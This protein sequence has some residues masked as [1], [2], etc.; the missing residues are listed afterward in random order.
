MKDMY[1]II[2]IGKLKA[3]GN[4]AGV[5]SHMMRTRET[6]NSDGREN[7]VL[8]Q[9]PSLS[10][11]MQEISLYMPRKNAVLAYD[12]LLTASPEFFQDKTPEQV[13]EWAQDAFAWACRK[14]GRENI[15]GAV[16]HL[17][18][19]T[20]PHLQILALPITPDGER[21]CARHYTGGRE[22]MRALWTEYAAAMK[23]WGLVRGREYSPAKHVDVR[24]YYQAVNRA[25]ELAKVR[26][27]RP[28]ELPAP[29]LL[30]RV[31]PRQ[32]AADLINRVT[33]F[34]RRENSALR[35]ELAREKRQR[36]ALTR[37][38]ISERELFHALQENPEL[39]RQLEREL[40][41]ERQGRKE[42]RQRYMELAAAIKTF[43]RKNVPR[44]SKLRHPDQL[45]NLQSFPEIRDSIRISIVPDEQER[46]GMERGR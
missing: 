15:K 32:Y 38:M 4:I 39:F 24:D 14:F 11:V 19:N 31:S 1:A 41:A 5:L 2:G 40:T 46:Q 8:I 17:D 20:G 6:P 43:F 33:E 22:K 30:D 21:L 37:Q 35:V 13:Q 44:N 23:H 28:E 29:E 18:E 9:P 36:E 45:G 7:T 25:V 26:A 42:D 10:E 27:V 16:L 12:M 34:I 3:A